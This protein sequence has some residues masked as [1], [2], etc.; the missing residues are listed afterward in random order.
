[1]GKLTSLNRQKWRTHFSTLKLAFG[2]KSNLNRFPGGQSGTG[3]E[4]TNKQ[5]QERTIK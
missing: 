3:R 5:T 1:M 2:A 4:Q